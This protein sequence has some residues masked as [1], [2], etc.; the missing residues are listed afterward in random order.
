MSDYIYMKIPELY[1]N[2]YY[3]ILESL[4]EY[5]VEDLKDCKSRCSNKSSIVIECFNMFRAAMAA[6][7]LEDVSARDTFLKYVLARMRQINKDFDITDDMIIN[8]QDKQNTMDKMQAQLKTI[9][10]KLS[11]LE[12]VYLELKID[13]PEMLYNKVKSNPRA[14]FY[15]YY[16]NYTFDVDVSIQSNGDCVLVYDLEDKQFTTILT[17]LEDG[18]FGREDSYVQLN[19]K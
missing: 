18:T 7:E 16:E 17:K 9:N 1:A 6:N 13:T 15:G 14:S 10:E 11:L 3:R 8:S 5:G 2:L 4:V 12:P 19:F